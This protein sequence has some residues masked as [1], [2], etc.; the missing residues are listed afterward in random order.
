MFEEMLLTL[1]I[2]ISRFEWPENVKSDSILIWQ[3]GGVTYDNIGS[4]PCHGHVFKHIDIILT[5]L[6]YVFFVVGSV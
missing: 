1:K 6:Q 2:S 5:V 4:P 3:G